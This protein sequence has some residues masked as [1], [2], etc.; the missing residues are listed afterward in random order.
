MFS[1]LSHH[2][3]SGVRESRVLIQLV[4]MLLVITSLVATAWWLGSGRARPG[5]AVALCALCLIA[6]CAGMFFMVQARLVAVTGKHLGT[7]NTVVD[8]TTRDAQEV[9]SL[10]DRIAAQS[11]TVRLVASEVA[12]KMKR[13]QRS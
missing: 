7:L 5:S 10:K 8:Q 2:E 13:P 11:T 6:V 3:G 1:L 9:A 4:G 12:H